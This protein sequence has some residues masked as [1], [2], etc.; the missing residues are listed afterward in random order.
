VISVTNLVASTGHDYEAA[1]LT[2]GDNY[3]TDRNYYI[4]GIPEEFEGLLWIKTA[5][6]DKFEGLGYALDFDVD[7]RVILYVAYDP[8]DVPPNWITE[9]FT[10]VG[11]SI[12]VS[13]SGSDV[14]NLWAREYPAGHITLYGNKEAGAGSG[15]K[16]NYLVLLDC[17]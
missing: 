17:R 8:R 15:V 4:Q 1:H 5:N 9:E 16:T 2:V 7:R 11:H 6:A 13:D 14:L 12:D 10:P 3:Y